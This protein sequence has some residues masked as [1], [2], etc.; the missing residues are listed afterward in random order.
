MGIA[1]YNRGSKAISEQITRE[2]QARKIVR[3]AAR[4][5]CERCFEKLWKHGPRSTEERG[6]VWSNRLNKW[7]DACSV[8]K[9][10]IRRE[11]FNHDNR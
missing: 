8:C 10:I 11:N 5:E 1:A 9:D 7:V 3:I 6:C 4:D 2:L